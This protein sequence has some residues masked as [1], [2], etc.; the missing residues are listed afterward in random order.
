LNDSRSRLVPARLLL[1]D[2]YDL[3]VAA[4][5]LRIPSLWLLAQPGKGHPTAQIPMAYRAVPGK[6]ASI[7]L[8][9][10]ITEDP[11]FGDSLRRW[12]DDL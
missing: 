2:R 10:P 12:L 3:G 5:S 9:A 1:K 7:W 8:N 6:K 11:H 4:A